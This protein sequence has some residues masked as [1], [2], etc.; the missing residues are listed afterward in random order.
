MNPPVDAPTSSATAPATSTANVSSACASLIPP[1][2]TYGIGRGSQP[3]LRPGLH[4]VP[5][6]LDRPIAR[7]HLAG[8][9]QRPGLLARRRQPLGDDREVRPN[10]LAALSRRRRPSP[11]AFIRPAYAEVANPTP[12]RRMPPRS[13]QKSS[14]MGM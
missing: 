6:L 5:R 8:Q 12:L 4:Q 14:V 3:E 10:A 7:Q 13:T 2:E 1:R 11:E 9:D